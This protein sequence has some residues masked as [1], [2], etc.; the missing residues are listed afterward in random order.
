L[1]EYGIIER[2]QTH[3]EKGWIIYNYTIY[4]NPKHCRNVDVE[5]RT[6]FP[7]TVEPSTVNQHL[8]NI[9]KV[10]KDKEIE[11]MAD[12]AFIE[13]RR[14]LNVNGKLPSDA[15]KNKHW[16]LFC[17]VWDVF[18][19]KRKGTC[20]DGWAAFK[21]ALSEKRCTVD[22]IKH[23][24][25]QYIN[26][27]QALSDGGK[28]A[29]SIEKWFNKNKW[30]E[31]YEQFNQTTNGRKPTKT[32]NIADIL[33]Q[34]AVE[35]GDEPPPPSDKGEQTLYYGLELIQLEPTGKNTFA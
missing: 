22:E 35:R 21:R 12:D 10:N 13:I 11:Y 8:I 30:S 29:T 32:D 18:P 20:A 7:S 31:Q 16:D 34:R 5:P 24:V 9:D 25:Q 15:G 4:Q 2:E 27:T 17:D 3:D 26:S 19:R 33:H 6:G 23:G 28:Y 1:I 14:P